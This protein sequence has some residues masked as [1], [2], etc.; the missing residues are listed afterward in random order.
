MSEENKKEIKIE[1]PTE[2]I[3]K[4]NKLSDFLN[5]IKNK[6]VVSK[7]KVEEML[8]ILDEI[9]T[10][11]PKLEIDLEKILGAIEGTGSE[12]KLTFNEVKLDG[13]ISLK[14]IPLVREKKEENK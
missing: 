5:K 4:L 10:R 6:E 9:K 2:L 7:D 8:K 1:I 12:V 3:E 11:L 14:I 13:E